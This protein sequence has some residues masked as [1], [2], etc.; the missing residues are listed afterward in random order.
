[1]S[2]NNNQYASNNKYFN[3]PPRMAD[4]RHFTDYRPNCDLNQ[5]SN[6]TSNEYRNNLINNAESIME[7]NRKLMCDKNCCGKCVE[8]YDVGT[9]LPEQTN[10]VCDAEKCQLMMNHADGL[11]QGRL[12]ATEPEAPTLTAMFSKGVEYLGNTTDK[13]LNY[14]GGDLKKPEFN[15]LNRTLT[16][17][18]KAMGESNLGSNEV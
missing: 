5:L 8:G 10:V 12:Y 3:C 15:Y 2:Q 1:M 4:G 9:M 16:D 7:N 17:G 6:V 14:F 13:V 18:S 11:G